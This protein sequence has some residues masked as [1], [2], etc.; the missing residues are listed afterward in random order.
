MAIDWANRMYGTPTTGYAGETNMKNA[1]LDN[2]YS[3][4]AEL[5]QNLFQANRQ[6]PLS[7]SAA[8]SADFLAGYAQRNVPAQI[9]GMGPVSFNP[10]LGPEGVADPNATLP[11]TQKTIAQMQDEA[12]ARYEASRLEQI[13]IAR[14]GTLRGGADQYSQARMAIEQQRGLS[15]T[16]GLT[17]GAREGARQTLSATEQV[18][19]NQIESNTLNRLDNLDAIAAELPM[20]AMQYAQ[21]QL[22]LSKLTDSRWLD[23]E[24]TDPEIRANA[25][26]SLYGLTPERISEL[27]DEFTGMSIGTQEFNM[28]LDSAI[29]RNLNNLSEDPTFWNTAFNLGAN[30]LTPVVGAEAARR[31]GFGLLRSPKV[32]ATAAKLLGK[33]GL[34]AIGG[35][36]VKGIL[37]AAG[38]IGWTILAVGVGFAVYNTYNAIQDEMV[39]REEP[40]EKVKMVKD[41]VR[42]QS[43]EFEQ[44]GYTPRQIRAFW[45]ADLASRGYGPNVIKEALGAVDG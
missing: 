17:A 28:K 2:P 41:L 3:T 19:L 32:Q 4:D 15:D 5:Y 31:I 7:G 10:L 6:M 9:S 43:A 22:E 27:A 36:A 37:A 25:I 39:K 33:V 20:E 38:P 45:Q 35:A 30:A 16:R 1:R 11:A 40:A 29:E 42:T 34:K 8:G 26:G 24:S 23:V 44:E 14:Q 13:D 21:Q 18:A 12:R